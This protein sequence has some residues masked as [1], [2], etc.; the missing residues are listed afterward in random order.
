MFL[1]IILA[2]WM[3]L[4]S[5][6]WTQGDSLSSDQGI[7]KM[8]ASVGERC[9]AAKSP[10]DLDS[11]WAEL[12]SRS[13]SAGNRG[14]EVQGAVYLVGQ[15]RDYL[16]AWQAGN[17][18]EARGIL[19]NLLENNTWISLMPRSKVLSI[20]YEKDPLPSKPFVINSVEDLPG[21]IRDLESLDDLN[22]QTQRFFE[23]RRCH[24]ILEELWKQWQE[25]SEENLDA[26]QKQCNYSQDDDPLVEKA[27]DLIRP[28]VVAWFLQLDP[29]LRLTPEKGESMEA[30]LKR[31]DKAAREQ[32]DYV[33]L[34]KIWTYGGHEWDSPVARQE[35]NGLDFYLAGQKQE[36]AGNLSEAVRFYRTA[37][38]RGD[39]HFVVD[40]AGAKLDGIKRN[41]PKDYDA[42]QKLAYS[43]TT[44]DK[45][46]SA[47]RGSP[48]NFPFVDKRWERY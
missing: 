11:L 37:L 13:G 19:E 31:L 36:T 6:A 33:A 4:P 45:K 43:E 25:R 38:W 23:L 7:R 16:T 42:G 47:P 29:K 14:A 26:L 17:K 28:Y 9:L 44:Q 46:K 40:I 18:E 32:K 3:L 5:L 10:K 12:A 2:F 21:V 34:W 1:R 35:V 24:L 41:F 39:A 15:W 48:P 20:V 30:Y 8:L 27:K 22:N